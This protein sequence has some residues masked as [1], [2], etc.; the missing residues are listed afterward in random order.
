MGM[1]ILVV[2]SGAREHALLWKLA[3]SPHAAALFC[4]PGNAGTVELAEPVRAKVRDGVLSLGHAKLLAGVADILEQQRLA[5][6]VVAQGL[7]VRNLER[8]LA[9]PIAP[10]PTKAPAAGPSAAHQQELEKSISRQLGLRVQ[11]KQGAKKGKGRLVLH[12]ANL[13]Q[14][15]ELMQRLNINVD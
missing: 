14:F 4:A 5:D 15:D 13:D 10:P 8:L 1:R 6:L 3:Q 2:G 12:Y 11:V 7:S 9:D